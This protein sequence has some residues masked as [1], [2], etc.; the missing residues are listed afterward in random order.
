MIKTN[1]LIYDLWQI[2]SPLISDDSVLEERQLLYWI[3]NNRSLW[4]HR[5]LN[6]GFRT[7]DDAI[8]QS[9]GAVEFEI[10]DTIENNPY[11][12][13]AK[14]L[15]SKVPIPVAIELDHGTAITR[16]GPLDIKCKPF[17]FVNYSSV[18]FV[19]HGKFNSSEIFCFLKD[20]YMY[21]TSNCNNPM[22]KTIKYVNIRGVFETPEEVGRFKE[23]DGSPCWTYDSAYPINRWMIDYLKGEIIKSDLKYFIKPIV[24]ETNDANP[25]PEE[26]TNVQK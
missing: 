23:L 15:K 1:E 26:I 25:Q 4:L 24:D 9:L 22:M 7:V 14:I 21:I 12:G 5:E 2:V 20:G 11:T 8:V 6:K 16:V 17:K 10:V 13:S 18:P 3:N 19:G